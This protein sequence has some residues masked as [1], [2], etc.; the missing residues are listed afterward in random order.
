[1]T[2][3]FAG[4]NY[5]VFFSKSDLPVNLDPH[6]D[7]RIQ[8]VNNLDSIEAKAMTHESKNCLHFT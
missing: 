1:M 2:H 5:T 8:S 7:V 6:F 4:T 3:L